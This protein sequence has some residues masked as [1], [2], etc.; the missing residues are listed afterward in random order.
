MPPARSPAPPPPRPNNNATTI[1]VKKQGNLSI[2][3]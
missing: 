1:P 3:N 2:K